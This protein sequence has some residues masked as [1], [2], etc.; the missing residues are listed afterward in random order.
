MPIA[1]IIVIPMLSISDAFVYV[2]YASAYAGEAQEAC[3]FGYMRMIVIVAF[4]LISRYLLSIHL[5][6]QHAHTQARCI[7][8]A[9]KPLLDVLRATVADHKAAAQIQIRRL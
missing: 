3:G 6:D 2:K 5:L 7:G 4:H 1:K 8:A 9:G